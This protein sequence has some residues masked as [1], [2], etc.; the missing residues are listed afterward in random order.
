MNLPSGPAPLLHE[1]YEVMASLENS[2]VKDQMRLKPRL[3]ML[4]DQGAEGSIDAKQ[5]F[6]IRHQVNRSILNAQKRRE[7]LP[8][9]KY[10]AEL[11]VAKRREEIVGCIQ[12]NQVLILAGETGSGKSTQIPK[13]C[14]NADRGI[15]GKIGCTQPRR[16][17]AQSLAKR[18]AQELNVKWGGGVGC[19]VR[20]QDETSPHAYIKFM[21]D[22]ILL[23]ELQHDPMLRD[24]DT[25]IIDEAH[26]RSLNIDFIL[27]HLRQLLPQ[28]PDL[29]LIITSATID[30]LIFSEAFW[31]APIIEVS[32]KLFPVEVVY[33]PLDK[34]AEALG[35]Q[36][37]VDAAV[38]TV[39]QILKESTQGDILVFMPSERDIRETV[40]TLRKNAGHQAELMPLFGRLA[41]GDQQRVFQQGR[42]RRVIVATNIAETSLTL[43]GIRYVVDSGLA[44]VSRYS[45]STHTKRLPVE[46]I[47]QSNANQRRGRCGRVAEGICYRLYSQEDFDGRAAFLSPEIQRCNLAEVILKMKA[48]HLGDMET[49]PFI[50]PPKP[51]AVKSG[52]RLL[53]QLGAIEP[54]H[55]LTEIG[56][57]LAKLPMDPTIGRMILEAVKE[58]VVEEMVIIASGLSIQ[59]PRERPM[60]AAMQADDAHRPFLHPKSDF[61][62]LLNLWNAFHMEWDRL[63]TQNQLRKF[64]R[65]HFL[66]YMRM[67]EWRDIYQQIYS[68]LKDIRIGS[69]NDIRSSQKPRDEHLW[70]ACIHRSILSGL[71]TQCARRK[72]SNQYASAS[73]RQV[74]LFPGSVLFERQS[75]KKKGSADKARVGKTQGQ[76]EWIIS[77]ETVET[78]RTFARTNASIQPAWV[79]AL[80]R[81]LCRYSHLNPRW[82]GA[83]GRAVCTEV[84]RLN[85]LEIASKQVDFG[86]SNPAAAREIMIL[87]GFV[88]EHPRLNLPFSEDNQRVIQA[89]EERLTRVRHG[90]CMSL[91]DLL[92]DFY[93][94]RLPQAVTSIPGL[95]HH[96]KHHPADMEVMHMKAED[97]MHG[98]DASFSPD[99]FPDTIRFHE[100]TLAVDYAYAP[101]EKHDG[102]TLTLTPEAAGQLDETHLPWL[103]PGNRESLI[104][105]LLQSLPKNKRRLLMPIQDRARAASV[106]IGGCRPHEYL[107]E[108]GHWL[109]KRFEVTMGHQAWELDCLPE[110]LRP[111]LK[112]VTSKGRLIHEGRHLNGVDRVIQRHGIEQQRDIWEDACRKWERHDIHEWSFGDLPERVLVGTQGE[113]PLYAYPGLLLDGERIAVRLFRDRGSA[114]GST[115][116][117]WSALCAKN[118]D[119]ELAWWQRDLMSSGSLEG[120]RSHYI[121][122]GSIE[123]FQQDA[124]IC[125]TGF[126]FECDPLLPLK[127]EAYD[128]S[129]RQGRARVM[130]LW[131]EA[132]P[133][134]TQILEVRHQLTVHES[135]YHGLNAD[136]TSLFPKGWLRHVS[137]ARL[138][139]YP[140]YL[141]AMGIR[142][143]RARSNSFK[144]REKMH[145]LQPWLHQLIDA[146]KSLLPG[147]A[148][149]SLWTQ[150]RWM[151]EEYKVSLFAQELGTAGSVSEKRM[152]RLLEQLRSKK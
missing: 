95:R 52:F 40:D 29:K 49:F 144:D 152:A 57:R 67:R 86:R 89:V 116:R 62:S 7:G 55:E 10:P 147:D 91:D 83:S 77:A 16:V 126:L 3:Q 120:A 60:E 17:A 150:L 98:L 35:N 130:G 43:P 61:L 5:F 141:K 90:A 76:P 32:G 42:Q 72:D 39:C 26:E 127:K 113:Q 30:T 34:E 12:S 13:M 41:S 145:R 69:R 85:G 92:F 2:M 78:S 121:S 136:L 112:V 149:W 9:I 53:Q 99:D 124:F 111:R 47:A 54:S 27:G 115:R 14:L 38:E 15:R 20:F 101:G 56:Q 131:K 8:S 33:R 88:R 134:L 63:K 96:Y 128:A 24:Y 109:S 46:P 18:V 59:D 129:L 142:S 48:F 108:L 4:L 51:A 118:F 114:E 119:R 50:Q 37:Y 6:A 132:V 135:P 23:S 106:A 102:V 97:L 44:R 94:R 84:V 28:R 125:L 79:V 25:L 104:V 103:I 123:E 133:L 138:R 107:A 80:G 19:K 36:S 122:M 58:D 87:E 66:S 143:E 140:R 65:R 137:Y 148:R 146:H 71:L 31:N 93:D 45:P 22:G 73:G 74:G 64:C 81:H 82:D 68:V 105:H 1:M 100:H 110:H 21:T 151:L 11:P 117:G 139:H 70:Y 75:G